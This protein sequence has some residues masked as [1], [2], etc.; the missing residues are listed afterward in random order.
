MGE[1]IVPN[2]KVISSHVIEAL[3]FAKEVRIETDEA[4]Q[5]VGEW[6]T[7]T[8][9]IR[10]EIDSA[11]DPQIESAKSSLAVAKSQK[12]RYADPYEEAV[13]IAKEKLAVWYEKKQ[14]LRIETEKVARKLAWE[15]A[16]A[17]KARKAAALTAA[18]KV[19][20]ARAVIERPTQPQVVIDTTAVVPKIDKLVVR[21][22]WKTEIYD[23]HSLVKAVA[24][25]KVSLS[26]LQ[27]NTAVINKMATALG[28]DLLIPGV[29]VFQ[30]TIIAAG[31]EE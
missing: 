25:G 3:A 18:G 29:R 12:A 8:N 4:Y 28:A 5:V 26:I 7:A 20:A 31:A 16:E 23:F 27:P 15:K 10:R 11:F 17:E 14:A 6:V 19:E 30:D 1:L 22:H 13:R 2:E 9:A 24:D 21:K